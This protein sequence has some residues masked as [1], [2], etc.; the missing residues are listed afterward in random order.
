M[1]RPNVSGSTD[2]EPRTAAVMFVNNTKD[3]QLAKNLRE[4][5]ER[6]KNILGYKI[7]IV[8]R[9]GTSLKQMFPLTRI[10]GNKECGREE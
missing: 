10:G 7:K 1:T 2:L 8:E 9:A 4:V 5:V 6:V 3:G